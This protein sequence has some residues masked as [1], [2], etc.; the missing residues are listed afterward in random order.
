[1]NKQANNNSALANKRVVIL[2]GSSGIGLATAKAAAAAGANVVIVSSNQQRINE[3]LSQ[4]PANATGLTTD[5][6]SEVAIKELFTRI[7]NFDHLAFTAGEN[8][9]LG[10]LNDA[11]IDEARQYF[12]LR[13]WGAVT[14]LKYAAPFINVNGSVVLTSGTAGAR[15]QAGWGIGASICAAMEGFTRAMAVELAPIRVNIVCPGFVRTP[16]WDSIPNADR[17]AMYIAVGQTLPVKHVGEA[18]E[19]AQTY[20]YLM[21]QTFSTGQAVV[22]DGGGVL[23]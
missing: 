7:G 17:E 14:A 6:N 16:L 18:D 8:I 13:Y 3:A 23:V 20:L 10:L 19:I 11:N 4:L 9:K 1:M 22:V 15:P 21:Q 5:L 2:G 12:N